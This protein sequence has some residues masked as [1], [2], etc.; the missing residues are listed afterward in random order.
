MQTTVCP[1]NATAFPLPAEFDPV[2]RSGRNLCLV[3]VKIDIAAGVPIYKCTFKNQ[4]DETVVT[5]SAASLYIGATTG[6]GAND[7]PN[8]AMIY[9]YEGPGIGEVLI[10]DDYVHTGGAV[11][12]LLQLHR[13]AIATLTSSSK[14]ITVAGEAATFKG[15]G[16]FGRIDAADKNELDTSDGVN[17]GEFVV[18]GGWQEIGGYL[19]NLTLPVINAKHL[20]QVNA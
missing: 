13:P 18:Y 12:L 6:N 8:G 9:V 7:R 17:D 1:S 4:V 19:K 16:L 2:D 15:T 20:T 3:P 14:F 5:Y 11:E 10:V